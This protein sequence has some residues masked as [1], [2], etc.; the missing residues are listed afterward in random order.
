M[1]ACGEEAPSC[2]QAVSSFYA[3]GCAFLDPNGAPY[4]EGQAAQSCREVNAA[5]PDRCQ[6][7]FDDFVRCLE[8]TSNCDCSREQDALFGCD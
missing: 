3:T 7:Q 4:S 5:V 6:A 8:S 2:Q 1:A